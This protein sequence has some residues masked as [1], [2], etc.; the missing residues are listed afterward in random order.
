MSVDL[1][2]SPH[3]ALRCSRAAPLELERTSLFES[4]SPFRA[5][6][7][8]NP[9]RRRLGRGWTDVHSHYDA[10]CMWGE[11]RI[12]G[13]SARQE[14]SRTR[15]RR[16]AALALGR[17][18][19]HHDHHGQLRRGGGPVPQGGPRLYGPPARG[20]RGHPGRFHQRRYHSAKLSCHLSD[21]Q[22]Y[23]PEQ[24]RAGRSRAS[25][26]R[27]TPSTWRRSTS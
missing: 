5:C 20:R 10:Q 7:R 11:S 14:A 12:V 24:V 4:S 26:G 3:C 17:R 23:L 16:P 6:A 18:R 9:R 2:S 19:R 15:L 1:L 25:S 8:A 21:P 13:R 22:T 27:P